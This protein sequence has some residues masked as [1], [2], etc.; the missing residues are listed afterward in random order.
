MLEHGGR[1]RAAAQAFDRPLADW[2]D[3]STGIA[4][5][6]F[7][8]PAIPA[9]AWSRL[10]EPD[11]SL[12]A[13]AAGYYGTSALLPVAG[14]QAA[15]QLLP[16]LRKH[17]QVGVLSPCYREHAEAWLREGHRVVEFSEGAV[18]RAIDGLDVL[19]VVNP[20]NPTG[21]LLS[22]E[23]LLAWHARLASRG[24]W[25]VVDE[26]FLD[27]TPTHSLAAHAHLPG[28]VVLRSFGKFFAMA[29]ARL[30]FVLAEPLL[31]DAL[32]RALGP[33]P[34]AGPSRFVASALLGD[35]AGQQR[36]RARLLADAERLARLL[37]QSGLPPAGGCALFQFVVTGDA[38]LLYEYLAC[39][40]ILVRRF[41]APP[42][43]RFGLPP[44][45]AGW[46]RLTRVLAHYR[47]IR[48]CLR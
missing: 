43:L 5:Y 24:G 16:R 36:Q 29:G 35:R 18:P 38:D 48:A 23:Q 4:P 12:A 1:L 33:W 7:E 27:C 3:L 22:P 19:V 42:S 41:H 37:T 17:L 25:L 31:L 45:A 21:R 34:V 40:G 13:V 47:E 39:Q 8:L 46:A 6:G 28:L 9:D 10:P 30:G 15:I 11:D 26:A 44:D 14:S 2:L 20:N 32:A